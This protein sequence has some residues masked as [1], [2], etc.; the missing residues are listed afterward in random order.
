MAVH[1]SSIAALLTL[2]LLG[3]A[4]AQGVLATGDVLIAND[5]GLYHLRDA[6]VT[7]LGTAASL[8]FSTVVGPAIEWQRDSDAVFVASDDRLLR[9]TVLSLR[10]PQVLVDDVTPNLTTSSGAAP[11]FLDLDVN[12]ATDELF[13]LESRDNR[14]LGYA[15]PFVPGMTAG[16]ELDVGAGARAMA[17]DSRRF[18]NGF[19]I[20][21]TQDVVMYAV[22]GTTETVSL[23]GQNSLDVDMQL[24]L[25]VFQA[26]TNGGSVELS[27]FGS[28]AFA[29]NVN[30]GLGC[31]PLVSRPTDVEWDAGSRYLYV[32]AENGLNPLCA[33]AF[34]NP[35][36]VVRFPHVQGGP[37]ETEVLTPPNDSGIDGSRGDLTVVQT[38]VGFGV[39]YGA[40]SDPGAPRL[41]H[42][43]GFAGE[44]KAGNVEFALVWTGGPPSA[45]T[46]L[47]VGYA[48]A[49]LPF[50]GATL[51]ATPDAILTMPP[52]DETGELV[53]G[54]PIPNDA[55]LVGLDL[56]L[57]SVHGSG[58]DWFTSQG[59]Q[60]RLD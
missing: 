46:S 50:V 40:P 36:H 51:W 55:S 38:P 57:Q 7:E 12:P 29:V 25:G 42:G 47:I 37:L 11:R 1:T 2:A 20:G 31:S 4:D 24:P 22:D 41:D 27:L 15:A 49:E 14:V 18:P 44:P 19:A 6:E 21:T 32:L 35:N 16:F 9:V 39:P 54:T 33:P 5:A 26:S 56:H 48:R 3:S 34:A 23:G 45:S 10:P 8:G 13:V 59:L 43:G 28:T 52:L 17:Y 60:L 30:V 58:G 53:L